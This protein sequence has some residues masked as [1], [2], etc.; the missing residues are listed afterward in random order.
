M[1][2]IMLE[3][4]SSAKLLKTGSN[5]INQYFGIIKG[6]HVVVCKYHLPNTFCTSASVLHCCD[7]ACTMVVLTR[8]MPNMQ[9]PL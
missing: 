1:I 3:L 6:I 4:S 7:Y 2:D 8:F 5:P 9:D